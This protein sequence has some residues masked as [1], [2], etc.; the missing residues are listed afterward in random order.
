MSLALCGGTVLTALHPAR[1]ATVDVLIEEG[2]VAALGAAPAGV[3]RRDCSGCLVVPGNV[4]AHT[5][6]Y[7]A[8]ARGMPYRLPPPANF[9]QIL[10]RVWWRL[11]RALDEESI[12]ASALVAG[13]EALLAGTT[14][15]IDHHAS[16]NAIDG[17]LDVIAEALEELGLRSVLCYEVTDRDGPE[18][19]GA[20]LRE[21]ARFL[22]EQRPLARGLV[23]AHASFTL[24]RETLAACVAL[25][26]EASRGVHIH[27]AEDPVDER[28]AE[29]RF[30]RRVV[31]RLAEA[32]ALDGGA[33]LA[34]CV[35]VDGAEAALIGERGA[36]VAH[37][38]RS[39]MHNA[40]GHAPLHRLGP[41]V[42]LGTD[43]IGSDM[44]AE[45][46]A[47]YWRGR[48]EEIFLSPTWPLQRLA[49]GADLAGQIFAEPLLG[50]ITPGAPAD[51][52]VLQYTPPTPLQEENVAGHWLFGLSARLVRDVL[53]AGEL[54]VA[55]RRL[56]RVDQ[57]A[58]AATAARQARRL[59]G[60]LEEIGPHDFVPAGGPG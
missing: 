57:E 13:M 43:G 18:R 4:N 3:P 37:N 45:S 12:R 33:V 2:R 56:V 35:H 39:N 10:Q 14:T 46:Q 8:L 51:L 27:V 25:A 32:G 15:V 54:V 24:S 34:H 9:L 31:H 59:W 16:P 36:T 41:R 20:G 58:V 7:S 26:R 49:A 11:D 38:A 47:A 44:F 30:R 17:S 1:L 40:V 6:L 29:A 22:R 53:V 48:E 21:N 60:R 52:A 23:G 19:A 42:V 55:D 5:H 50:R 28:D